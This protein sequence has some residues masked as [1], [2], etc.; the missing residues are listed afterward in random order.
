MTPL[1]K[2]ANVAL[3]KEIPDLSGVVVGV[4]W[5]AGPERSLS[6][7][8]ALLTILC[9][10]SGKA[11]SQEHVVYFNQL[12]S[13]DLSTAQLETAMGDDDEQVEIE[14]G[15]VPPE[16]DSIV[17]VLYFNEGGTG[18]RTLGQLR[19]C[20]VHLT[21]LDT[22]AP[23]LQTVDLADGLNAETAVRLGQIYRRAGDWKFKALGLGYSSGLT[24]LA[25]DFGVQ[26]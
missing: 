19:H 5:D 2:G 18:R 16:V 14:L 7:N 12:V 10:S 21:R 22:G 11:L 6:D 20:V 25:K 13:S 15:G 4:D 8:L 24:G 1:R 3:T 9:D 23:I 17:F 26:L